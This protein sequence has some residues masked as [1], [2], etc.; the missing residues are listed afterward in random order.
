MEV[1]AFIKRFIEEHE[2]GLS[3]HPKDTGNW[4]KGALVG[5]KYG[6]TPNALLKH[7]GLKEMTAAKMKQEIAALTISEA[8]DIG[9]SAYY[10]EPRFDLLVWNEV[11]AAVLDHGWISGPS[12]AIKILQ[13]LIGAADDGQLG[14]ATATAYNNWIARFGVENSAKAYAN[15]RNAFFTKLTVTRPANKAFLKGWM[16]RAN[17][18]LPGTV[19]WKGF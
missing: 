14:P 16:N 3:L 9:V 4:Y 13:R 8:V 19:W 2:G 12:Q 10:K 6:V 7:R 11:T 5:S 18:F 17:S 15:A 1:R